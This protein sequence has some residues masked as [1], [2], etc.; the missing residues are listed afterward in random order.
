MSHG[1]GYSSGI[2]LFESVDSL[3]PNP[4]A[5]LRATLLVNNHARSE[6]SLVQ[7]SC[8]ENLVPVCIFAAI[9]TAKLSL[10]HL[11]L[12]LSCNNNL[13]PLSTGDIPVCGLFI[14]TITHKYL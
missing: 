1:N 7:L 8:S 14:D 10:S 3:A 4:P 2:S 9:S 11:V 6:V 13:A 12:H 5:C